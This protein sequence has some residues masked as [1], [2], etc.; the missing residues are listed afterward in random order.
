MT[1]DA[2]ASG[3][4]E[5]NSGDTIGADPRFHAAYAGSALDFL[6]LRTA[7]DAQVSS[8]KIRAISGKVQN[9]AEYP[10][11]QLAN[12]LKLVARLIGGGLPT[13]VYYVSQG[14]YD[15]HTNQ[16]GTQQRLR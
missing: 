9:Q 12:S 2:G 3:G 7:M 13:R 5:G 6:E 11:S 10:P 4:G 15:T 8:D 14:G 16:V 1:M